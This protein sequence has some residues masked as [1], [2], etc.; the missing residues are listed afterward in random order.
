VDAL[1]IFASEPALVLAP[2]DG[3]TD[4]PMRALQGEFG[5]FTLAVTEF[6]RVSNEP[7][8][9]KVFRR[10]VPEL[11]H[12]GLTP[13]G[14]AVQVQILGGDAGR[15]AKSA[16]NAV[17]A[18]ARS[19]DI[20]FGCPAPVVNRH[21]G[22]ASLLQQPCR[23]LEVV[24]A[25]RDAVPAEIPVSAKL[26]LGWDCIDAIHHNAEMAAEGGA[27]WLTIHARTR[28][29]G[30][31]PPVYWQPIG[32]VRR[33]LGIPVVANGDIWTID[34]FRRCQDVTGCEHFMI[35]RAALARPQLAQQI[36]SEL[37]IAQKGPCDKSW[38]ELM[39]MLLTISAGQG[40]KPLTRMKQW[41]SLASK[42][43][44]FEHF[45]RVKRAVTVDELLAGL[46]FL[47]PAIPA[48]LGRPIIA[49]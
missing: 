4:A 28:M 46:E 47:R 7:V 9:R 36:A 18:G 39:L 40:A 1:S 43:G 15:M 32:R 45:D 35:G 42:F 25:V 31:A 2:M 34:D 48:S 27:S 24:R 33:D 21:D 13:T 29:Q 20:N 49:A 22:G 5:A 12:G 37:G 16:Q 3:I 44:E 10:E 41:L 38:T 6:I 8:P 11:E 23:I 19:L 30:Y 17:R 26:R 14:L